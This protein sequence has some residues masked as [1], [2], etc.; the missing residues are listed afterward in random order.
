MTTLRGHFDGRV[1][2][3]ETPVD[4]PRNQRLVIQVEPEQAMQSAQGTAAFIANAMKNH[5]INDED[6][7]LMRIAIE[8]NCERIN[9][10]PDVDFE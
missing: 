7:E 10:S 2:V 3:P 5:R 1:I 8:E 6:A 9:P 4:L